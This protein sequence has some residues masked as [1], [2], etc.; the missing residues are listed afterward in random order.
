MD[1]DIDQNKD[2]DLPLT[3]IIL[4][5]TD[6][7][8]LT[9]PDE[10]VKAEGEEEAA[11][12][13][14]EVKGD[15]MK[16]FIASAQDRTRRMH[17]GIKN[18]AG[19]LKTKIRSVS[20][21]SSPTGSP[22]AKERQQFMQADFSK[23]KMPDFK[24]IDFATL[25]KPGI[26]KIKKL[27][28]KLP[29][30]K[31][32]RRSKS[33]REDEIPSSKRTEDQTEETGAA[34]A[35]EKV[36]LSSISPTKAPTTTTTAPTS[37]KI[38]DFKFKTYP[39]ALRRGKKVEGD[40][41]VE[42]SFETGTT[43]DDG[44]GALEPSTGTQ[45]SFQS[46]S[47]PQGDRGPGPVRS[48]WADR[49][50]DVSFNDSEGSRYRRYGSELE[51]FD[52]ESSL[53]RQMMRDTDV[54]MDA[55]TETIGEQSSLG[56]MIGAGV[57]DIKE[58]ADYDEENRAIHKISS[59]RSKEFRRRPIS[60]QDSDL[61]SEDS[62]SEAIGWSEK[63][64]E[65]NALLRK[66]EMEAEANYLKYQLQEAA[67][68]ETQSTA[69]SSKKVVLEEIDDDEFFIRKRGIS[70]DNIEIRQYI[71]KAI[72]EGYDVPP[73]NALELMDRSSFVSSDYELT[74]GH[75]PPTPPPKPKGLQKRYATE[76]MSHEETLVQDENKN[77]L[78]QTLRTKPIKPPRRCHS[79]RKS[80]AVVVPVSDDQVSQY[81]SDIPYFDNDEEYLRPTSMTDTH[82]S[83]LN[84]DTQQR[85][86]DLNAPPN[87]GGLH[88]N[89]RP[90]PPLRQKRNRSNTSVSMGNL[91]E[92]SISNSVLQS[93]EDVCI[94]LKYLSIC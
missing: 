67:K 39:R 83:P 66:A 80:S 41:V 53:E 19:K 47:S 14:A 94:H 60:H 37:K 72:R 76:R 8:S 51:S 6:T 77:T 7:T 33:F 78:N 65:K 20:K 61:R 27:P 3:T 24:S 22:K 44:A 79:Q 31:G 88:S 40:A 58:F 15:G 54:D 9:V 36:T 86:N 50:S 38:F 90:Q 85:L 48:R 30:L 82:C 45:P 92:P 55:D 89:L 81:T 28:G 26:N 25:T 52:R 57:R 63:D 11:A 70:E 21:K 34:M 74:G 49:F 16:G 17:A 18:Q 2:K 13:T 5:A 91:R 35:D 93:N 69:S 4:D 68:Q 32:L 42:Q 87:N 23:L 1:K 56:R 75:P 59:Q 84:K 73:V 62:K 43:T 29:T 46:S 64:I 12:A 71:S 10:G